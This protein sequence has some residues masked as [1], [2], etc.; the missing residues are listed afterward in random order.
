VKIAPQITKS[1]RAQLAR[2]Q[3]DGALFV[4]DCTNGQFTRDEIRYPNCEGLLEEEIAKAGEAYLVCN[5][6]R[7]V[8]ANPVRN[9]IG[10]AEM[11]RWRD[12]SWGVIAGI[13]KSQG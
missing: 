2:T 13:C 3:H 1:H 12:R 10:A 9:F 8:C 6:M 11:Q 7:K 5:S 4:G